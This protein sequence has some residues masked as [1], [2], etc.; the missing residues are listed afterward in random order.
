VGDRVARGTANKVRKDAGNG[1][2]GNVRLDVFLLDSPRGL[3]TGL[4][5]VAQSPPSWRP[6]V[7]DT[8]CIII[9]RYANE[10]KKACSWRC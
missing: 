7:S 4:E 9:D 6:A 10:G 1:V 3:P 8:I 2:G 5:I